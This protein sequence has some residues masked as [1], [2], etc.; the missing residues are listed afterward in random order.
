MDPEDQ[1]VTQIGLLLTNFRYARR[2]LEDIERST[3]RYLGVSFAPLFSEGP[4]FG[5]PPLFNG[6]LKVHVVNINDLTSPPAGGFL[7]AIFGGI[8]RFI[9][10]LVGGT[11]GGVIGGIALPYNL[12][13]LSR[14]TRQ[15]DSIAARVER[16]VSHLKGP[17]SAPRNEGPG[18]STI[19]GLPRLSALLDDVAALLRAA[20][21]QR[22]P[23]TPDPAPSP[24][25]DQVLQTVR[26]I[27]GIVDG[28]ILLVPLLNGFLA[29]MILRLDTLKLA[30]VDLLDF[31]VRNLF[32]LRGLV[33]VVVMD[34]V[35]ALARLGSELA[36]IAGRMVR[37]VLGSAF[38]MVE[39][40][41]TTA[42]TAVRWISD[43]LRLTV[44]D[45][46]EWMRTG[47][48]N[49][50]I[51]FG[52][53]PVT[54]YL[55]HF[56]RT[57]PAMLPALLRLMDDKG[58]HRLTNAEMGMLQT[59]TYT[60]VPGITPYVG[61]SG[62][63]STG[64]GAITPFPD[65]ASRLPSATDVF[66]ELARR[67]TALIDA[68][69]GM[70]SSLRSGLSDMAAAVRG[71]DFDAGMAGHLRTVRE[72]AGEFGAALDLARR[73]AAVTGR[74]DTGLAAIAAAYEGWLRGG[75]FETL[76]G[77]ITAHFERHKALPGAT[78]T[79][80]PDVARATVEIERVEIVIDPPP[81]P[82]PADA[83]TS[84]LPGTSRWAETFASMGE[85]YRRGAVPEPFP[86]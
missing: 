8:G 80:V 29:S 51:Y 19:S 54:R 1:I 32:L 35:A 37:D 14:I 15:I 56:L 69:S 23:G 55:F 33:L 45:L 72:R 61:G 30:I 58:E 10:G 17:V 60:P 82:A 52:N 11:V 22:T 66:A 25:V 18:T 34:T 49:L 73:D 64:G 4:R 43:A 74:A 86:A 71:A 31:F 70:A 41:V 24:A 47:L 77:R 5:A 26:A 81:A 12:F 85:D 48:G 28:A 38:S 42:V 27:S 83:P 46:M 6:A 3:S 57:L 36:G 84:M 39:T 16:I 68:A 65:L 78:A 79:S 20:S 9:G 2:A 13:E 67:R 59:A 62:G 50:L 21:G 40:I 75:G 53:L 7:E 76:L 44:N 63:S